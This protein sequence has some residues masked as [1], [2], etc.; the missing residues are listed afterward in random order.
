MASERRSTRRHLSDC[1]T[2]IAKLFETTY[3]TSKQDHSAKQMRP[4][5]REWRYMW[6]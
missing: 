1:S 3:R 6:R 4:L 5:T 2:A